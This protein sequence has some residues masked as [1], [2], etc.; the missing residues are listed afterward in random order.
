MNDYLFDTQIERLKETFGD[1]FYSDSRK[2]LI[3]SFVK[4]MTDNWLQ[5]L[6]NKFLSSAK[7][8]PLPIEFQDAVRSERE[9]S[10]PGLR[11]PTLNEIHP[12]ENSI[13]SKEDIA[14]IF[15]MIRKRLRG[16][17]S[18]AQLEQYGRMIE[19]LVKESEKKY[20]N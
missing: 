14:E 5:S 10:Q 11:F 8:P 17:I 18:C 4:D 7:N 6:V 1:R 20:A 19:D 9:K 13:F 12:S 15:E 2:A 3:W 16:E